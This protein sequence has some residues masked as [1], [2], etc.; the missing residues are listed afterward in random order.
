MK[1]IYGLVF[2]LV[3][4]VFRPAISNAASEPAGAQKILISTGTASA[5]PAAQKQAPKQKAVPP[6]ARKNIQKA[7]P[8]EEEGEGAV[9]IDSRSDDDR[10]GRFDDNEAKADAETEEVNVPGGMPSSYGQL[11]GAFNDGGRSLLVFENEDG[12]MAL[13]QI[14]LG[15]SEVTWKLV[16]KIPRSAD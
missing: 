5:A 15:K 9:M 16:S 8:A 12:L 3:L 4:A 2:I 1:N 6:A 14:F 10:S 7:A 13:V 11:K